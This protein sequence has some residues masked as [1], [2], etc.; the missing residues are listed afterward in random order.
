[1]LCCV[2]IQVVLCCAEIQIVLCCAEIQIV[3]CCAEIQGR[4]CEKKVMRVC[5][6]SSLCNICVCVRMSLWGHVV[7]QA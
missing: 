4:L 1:M 6:G 7:V 5:G 2:E 3:L